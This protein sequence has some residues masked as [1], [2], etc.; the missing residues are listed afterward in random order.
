[1]FSEGQVSPNIMED[2]G[3][4]P[5]SRRSSFQERRKPYSDNAESKSDGSPQKFRDSPGGDDEPGFMTPSRSSRKPSPRG[6]RTIK[7]DLLVGLDDA[8]EDPEDD[9]FPMDLETEII[10]F[11]DEDIDDVGRNGSGPR[12]PSMDNARV[13]AMTML[14]ETERRRS[15][16]SLACD[17]A[18]VHSVGSSSASMK[19]PRRGRRSE[20]PGL[21]GAGATPPND[22]GGGSGTSDRFRWMSRTREGLLKLQAHRRC[23]WIIRV[24]IFLVAV[25]LCVCFSLLAH[26]PRSSNEFAT[27]STTSEDKM[28]LKQVVDIL[29]DNNVSTKQSLN[30]PTS[31]QHKA[32]SWLV[33]E[34]TEQISVNSTQFIQ[35]YTLAVLY[36]AWGGPEWVRSFNFLSSQHECGWFESMDDQDG[37]ASA[38]GVTCDQRLQVLGLNMGR[39]F[40]DELIGTSR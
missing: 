40:H 16:R 23:E 18:S 6:S 1:M 28:R 32:L 9:L 12:S 31:P 19:W 11:K 2:S 3:D 7:L 13:F 38:I 29:V 5:R 17:D 20:F 26:K 4:I 22:L 34:D 25:A 10:E 35:R 39:Y 33:L 15:Q 21:R 24:A 8:K 36:Y 14:A 37:M 27:V 30:D